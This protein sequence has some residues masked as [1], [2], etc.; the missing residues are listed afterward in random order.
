MVA[1]SM[2]CSVT[3][4]VCCMRFPTGLNSDQPLLVSHGSY[5]VDFVR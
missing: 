3:K 5:K 4:E 1:D 2:V